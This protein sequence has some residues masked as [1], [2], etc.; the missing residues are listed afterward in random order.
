M[1]DLDDDASVA[2]SEILFQ[3]WILELV[4]EVPFSPKPEKSIH[5]SDAWAAPGIRGSLWRVGT[6]G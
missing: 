2:G 5:V 3:G 1:K 6:K 4:G